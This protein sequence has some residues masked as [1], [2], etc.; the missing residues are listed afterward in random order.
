M[1]RADGVSSVQGESK[2]RSLILIAGFIHDISA[3]LDHHPGGKHYLLSNS[4]KEMT[5]AFFGG[6]YSHSNAAHNVGQSN[7]YP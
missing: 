1:D 3:F 5:A 7:G 6:I 4:G 2:T